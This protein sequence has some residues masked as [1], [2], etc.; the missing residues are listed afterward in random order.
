MGRKCSVKRNDKKHGQV[1]AIGSTVKVSKNPKPYFHNHDLKQLNIKL[2]K[3][4]EN[5]VKSKENLSK[6]EKSLNDA[7]NKGSI[8]SRRLQVYFDEIEKL[9]SEVKTL[10]ENKDDIEIKIRNFEKREEVEIKKEKGADH[11]EIDKI[12]LEE[13]ESISDNQPFYQTQNHNEKGLSLPMLETVLEER[14]T[15]D[16]EANINGPL[17]NKIVIKDEE[18]F[19]ELSN[20]PWSVDDTSVF[21]KFCCPECEYQIAEFQFFSDHAIRNHTKASVLFGSDKNED[22]PVIK[23]EEDFVELSNNPWSV[24]DASVFL[25]FCCPECD[26]QIAELQIFSD[27]AVRNHKK[28]T[29]LFGSEEIIVKGDE[30]FVQNESIE[31]S[32]YSHENITQIAVTQDTC[33]V[34]EEKGLDF[35]KNEELDNNSKSIIE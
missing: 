5:L 33:D 28:S 13:E 31:T 17:S 24:D 15:K 19:V 16:F 3:V 10:N 22:R 23:E 18:D 27:H 21:L 25:K 12:E 34:N 7:M 2:K 30:D 8:S 1:E 26:Y 20:N 35:I 29:V 4:K 32:D 14:V 9:S 11:T 6:G